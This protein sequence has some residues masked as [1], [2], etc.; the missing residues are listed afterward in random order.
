[1]RMCAHPLLIQPG[2][3]SPGGAAGPA[4]HRT[5]SAKYD[6]ASLARPRPRRPERHPVVVVRRP[7]VHPLGGSAQPNTHRV[8]LC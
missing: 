7:R 4:H 5:P 3:E 8:S 1:M 2:A 6:N